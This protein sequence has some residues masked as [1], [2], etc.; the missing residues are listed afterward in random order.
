MA[1]AASRKRPASA[2]DARSVLELVAALPLGF[3]LTN[4]EKIL[5][6][7]QN[8]RKADLV[9]YAAAL[10]DW[11]LPHVANRPLTLVR[12]PEGRNKNCFYQ[13]HAGPGVPKVV[14]RVEIPEESGSPATYMTVRDLSGLVALAQLGVLEIHAW[15]CHA[16][17][18]ERPDQLVF[19]VDPD[20][21]L[22]FER[23]V[24]AALEL[25]AQLAELGLESFVKTTGGKGLHVVA[26]VVRK[27]GWDEHKA[28]ARA[29]AER[30]ARAQPDRYTLNSRRAERRGRIFLDYL[31]NGRGATAVV[32]YSP[33]ARAGAPVATPL[34]WEELERGVDPLA[35]TVESVPK[36][37]A[38]LARDPWA[39]Y[40]GLRQ[41]IRMARPPRPAP[42]RRARRPRG[43]PRA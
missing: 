38:K 34:F 13:K 14:R 9:A 4:F 28:F 8:L 21:A 40:A 43:A 22:P 41:G 36:R 23:T 27:H 39:A 37:I 10:A 31:R 12:C 17:K 29:V 2:P 24:A 30:M 6:P 5:Y 32:P 35:F 3:E 33:R 1:R 42:G 7:E 15:L 18:L 26:P 20:T 19:D 25:R 11:I 16:D